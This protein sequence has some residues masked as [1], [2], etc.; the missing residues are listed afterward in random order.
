MGQDQT[1]TTKTARS[2]K[3]GWK[4]TFITELGTL[5]WDTMKNPIH[6]LITAFLIA[7][8]CPALAAEPTESKTIIT[9]ATQSAT[10]SLNEGDRVEIVYVS[11]NVLVHC[12]IP[13]KTYTIALASHITPSGPSTQGSPVPQ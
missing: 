1:L 10:Y 2:G 13:G 5:P 7:V 12:N 3:R 9:A 8:S 6:N 11:G 4:W